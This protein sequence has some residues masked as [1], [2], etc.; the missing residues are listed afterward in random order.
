MTPDAASRQPV[1]RRASGP[2]IETFTL[3]PFETNCYLVYRGGNSAAGRPCWIV[4]ASFGP[5]PI[6]ARVRRLG[7]IP[8]ALVLTHAHADHIA[9]VD[10]ICRAFPGVPVLVHQAERDWLGDPHRNLSAGMGL[11]LVARGP[12]AVLSDG[13]ELNLDGLRCRVIHVPGHSPGGVCLYFPPV[14][15]GDTGVAL[16]GDALFAGSIGR[17]DF[18]GSDHDR[19]VE[20]IRARLYT[21]PDE[22]V[23]YPGHGPPTT[24]ARERR[25]NPFVRGGRGGTT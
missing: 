3:G 15:A 8:E 14:E 20:A 13:Q 10:E 1:D 6:I 16:V 4:D 12:D 7:L 17:T 19:L 11:Q 22:T 5:T 9:G 24:I 2:V 18:P 21:L 23:V 25:S